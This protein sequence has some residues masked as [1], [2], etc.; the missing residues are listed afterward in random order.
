[1]LEITQ[2]IAS[3]AA[4]SKQEKRRLYAR[5]TKRATLP[6]PM[7][8]AMI[9]T[10]VCALLRLRYLQTKPLA[11]VIR[12]VSEMVRLPYVRPLKRAT[13]PEPMEAATMPSQVFVWPQVLLNIL[14]ARLGELGKR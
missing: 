9:Q 13:L 10:Q 14:L 11:P 6:G 8:T 4:S 12:F 1:M 2:V 5:S 3:K 7:Q